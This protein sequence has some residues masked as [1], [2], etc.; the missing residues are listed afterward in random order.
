MN[1]QNKNYFYEIKKIEDNYSSNSIVSRFVH[2]VGLDTIG[3]LK[4]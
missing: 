1:A 2:S 3:Q 4:V